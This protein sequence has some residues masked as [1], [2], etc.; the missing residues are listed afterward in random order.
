MVSAQQFENVEKIPAKIF[1]SGPFRYFS[2][3]FRVSR[4]CLDII[5]CNCDNEV[6]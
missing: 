5:L 3:N 4:R 1:L 6:D 2:W